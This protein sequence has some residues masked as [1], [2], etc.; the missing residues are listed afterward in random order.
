MPGTGGS[1]VKEK[2]CVR[3]CVSAK[4]AVWR[5]LC[6]HGALLTGPDI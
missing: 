2:V 5:G 4:P 3:V 1:W 6:A